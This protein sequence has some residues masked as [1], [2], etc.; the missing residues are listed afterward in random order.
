MTLVEM[1]KQIN[2]TIFAL[3][4][5]TI[6]AVIAHK[7]LDSLAMQAVLAGLS[8][9]VPTLVELTKRAPA[10]APAPAYEESEETEPYYEESY[11]SSAC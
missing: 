9:T 8:F 2:E 1:Y 3:E 10:P 11:E 7:K 5:G 6:S 4:A